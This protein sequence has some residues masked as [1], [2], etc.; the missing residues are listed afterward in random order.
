MILV[1]GSQFFMNVLPFLFKHNEMPYQVKQ[2]FFIKHPL[3]QHF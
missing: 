1:I 3:E 2:Y